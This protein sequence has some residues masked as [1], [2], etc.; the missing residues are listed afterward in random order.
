MN[1]TLIGAGNLATNLGKALLSTGFEIN[2]VYSRTKKSAELLAGKLDCCFTNDIEEIKKD[3]DFYICSLKDT[4]LEDVASNLSV[5]E[6][7]VVVH[8]A[9]SMPLDIIKTATT[10]HYG[11]LYPMQSFSKNKEVSFKE[12]PIFIE[13]SDSKSMEIIKFVSSSISDKIIELSSE[14]RKYIHLSAVFVCNFVNYMYSIGADIVG[15]TNLDFNLLIPLIKETAS[16]VEKMS[17]AESQ[18]GPAVRYDENVINKHIE[19]L[20]NKPEWAEIYR[21]LSDGIHNKA[22]LK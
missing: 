13:A 17:P 10:K 3:S 7:A 9:G 19:L 4:A 22:K 1:V 14:K 21:L 5:N 18:T 15:L 20:K 11:V 8:T 2:Q 12:I 6:N 16:K